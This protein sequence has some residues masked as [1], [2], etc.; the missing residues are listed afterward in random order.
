MILKPC[1]LPFYGISVSS[2]PDAV[3]FCLVTSKFTSSNFA[4]PTV[5]WLGNERT[6]PVRII[7]NSVLVRLCPM[8]KCAGVSAQIGGQED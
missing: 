8:N 4:L 2:F 7:V 6:K 5:K 3:T 1:V